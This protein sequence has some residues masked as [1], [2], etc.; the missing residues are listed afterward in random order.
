M[1]FL[2]LLYVD[3]NA[4]RAAFAG[5][6][7]PTGH[8]DESDLDIHRPKPNGS[9]IVVCRYKLKDSI[10]QDNFEFL[11]DEWFGPMIW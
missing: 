2:N 10:K 9:L 11:K 1:R 8:A 5:K 4:H 7:E 6:S 3:L